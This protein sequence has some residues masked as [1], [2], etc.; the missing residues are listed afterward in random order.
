VISELTTLPPYHLTTLPPYHL[1]TVPRYNSPGE[2]VLAHDCHHGDA[3]T[4]LS[5]D[6]LDLEGENLVSREW[7]KRAG[8]AGRVG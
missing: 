8:R 6:A 7:G 2:A 1:T 5:R 3:V 4:L